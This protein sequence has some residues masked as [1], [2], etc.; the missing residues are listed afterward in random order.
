VQ[1][2][3]EGTV[4]LRANSE[5]PAQPAGASSGR[6]APGAPLPGVLA[7]ALIGRIGDRGVP[8]GIGN[9][10][11]L[12]MPDAGQLFLG[13]NDDE[14][15]DNSGSFTVRLRRQAGATGRN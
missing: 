10:T 7:G 11:S 2:S 6:T 14:V 8:F 15:S 12:T 13:I 9:Q 1:L 3:S 5:D 4:Y